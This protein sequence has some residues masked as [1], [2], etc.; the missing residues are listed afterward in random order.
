MRKK[1]IKNNQKKM[2][3][4]L[5]PE[6]RGTSCAFLDLYILSPE[7]C[8]APLRAQLLSVEPNTP[9]RVRLNCD[10]ERGHTDRT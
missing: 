10:K 9:G 3:E 4:E 7:C 8:G 1:L 5:N 2:N 6:R